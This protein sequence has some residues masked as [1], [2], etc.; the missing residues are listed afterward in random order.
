[1][2]VQ[3]EQATGIISYCNGA[4]SSIS[5]LDVFLSLTKSVLDGFTIGM[6]G[7]YKYFTA[8]QGTQGVGLIRP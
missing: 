5:F 6:F 1:V 2:N 4:F 3:P 7:C 8:T